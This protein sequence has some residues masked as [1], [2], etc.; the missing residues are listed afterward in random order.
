VS[1]WLVMPAAGSGQRFGG[2]QPK[3]H[4]P[5]ADATVLDIS[6]RLFTADQR[7]RGMVLALSPG[8]ARRAELQRAYGA[9]LQIVDGG[10]Q[11]SESVLAGL[12]ALAS[13]A[14]EQDWVLVHDA[15]RPC[16]SV[17]DLERLLVAGAQAINGALLAAPVADTMK[18][19]DAEQCCESTL[20]RAGLWRALTPQMFRYRRLCD[21]LLQARLASRE[22]TDEAQALEWLGARPLLVAARDSNPK[23]TTADDLAVAAAILAARAAA[24]RQQG[25]H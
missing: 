10:A 16:L 17:A 8:D 22:P 12:G 7:C 23:I 19:A 11:R 18:A 21:A 15:V 4:A 14:G 24:A 25:Q 9:A 2:Q 20:P 1:Y 5:L 13:R 6:L 3:Q